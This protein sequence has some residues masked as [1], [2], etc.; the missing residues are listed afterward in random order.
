MTTPLLSPLPLT[1]AVQLPTGLCIAAQ[2][3]PPLLVTLSA[4]SI[5]YPLV[6]ARIQ[7]Q[8]D[9]PPCFGFCPNLPM[10]ELLDDATAGISL[11][12]HS[13]GLP[14]TDMLGILQTC[15]LSWAELLPAYSSALATLTF[16]PSHHLP[17]C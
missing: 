17:D 7:S 2:S 16:H 6:I 15:Q 13:F 12:G 1:L 11:F 5:G 3:T 8:L 14:F 10:P 4:P 9:T